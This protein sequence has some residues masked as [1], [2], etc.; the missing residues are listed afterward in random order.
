MPIAND[1]RVVLIP[2]GNRLETLYLVCSRS[3]IG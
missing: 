1:S 2:L 3:G